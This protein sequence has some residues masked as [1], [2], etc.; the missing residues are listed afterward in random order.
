KL[1]KSLQDKGIKSFQLVGSVFFGSSR[2]LEQIEMQLPAKK[3]ILDMS[4]V[5][6]ID[7]SGREYFAKLLDECKTRGIAVYLT[8]LRE[9][10][11]DI[12]VRTKWILSLGENYL[13]DDYN[14][15]IKQLN[16]ADL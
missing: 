13:Y 3:L 4:G 15:L 1:P 7:S 8:G 14:D 11:K 5:I 9:Q 10:P 2:L 6:Y 16:N 12:L